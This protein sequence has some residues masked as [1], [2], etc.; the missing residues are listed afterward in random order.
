L[1]PSKQQQAASDRDQKN[2]AD[3]RKGKIASHV[4]SP[5]LGAEKLVGPDFVS[6]VLSQGSRSDS[7]MDL[8][9]V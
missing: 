5:G 2:S 7:P 6:T 4:I 3:N 8:E 9:G 1:L